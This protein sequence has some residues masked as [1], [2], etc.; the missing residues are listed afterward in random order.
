MLPLTSTISCVLLRNIDLDRI[1]SGEV[2]VFFRRW[3]RPTVKT[4]GTLRTARGLLEIVSV[5][6]VDLSRI[7]KAEADRA[8]MSLEEIH[9]WLAGRDGDVYRIEVGGFSPDPRVAL[10]END[11]L[12]DG[13]VTE[14]V[15]KLDRLD[16]KS[17]TGPW[18]R[19][20]L[21]SIADQPHV[22]AED[23]ADEIGMEKKPFKDSVRKLKELG[24]TISHSPGYELSPRGKALRRRL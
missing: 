14:L 19:E 12:T 9:D 1:A 20:V 24:L 22:R 11:S 10:R 6:I 4:G 5:D 17:P 18:T 16:A 23:L 8:G 15:A 3:K 13:D 21:G 2:D 7:S